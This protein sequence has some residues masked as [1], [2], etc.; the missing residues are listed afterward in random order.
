MFRCQLYPCMQYLG[1]NAFVC[2]CILRLLMAVKFNQT[3]WTQGMPLTMRHI[4]ITAGTQSTAPARI[5]FTNDL[6]LPYI[7]QYLVI[8]TSKFGAPLFS[9]FFSESFS[10]A[11]ALANYCYDASRQGALLCDRLTRLCR[12]R[13]EQ[14]RWIGKV[15]PSVIKKHNQKTYSEIGQPLNCQIDLTSGASLSLINLLG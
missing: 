5:I 1:Q 4:C 13:Q 12:S 7:L 2:F 10:L 14:A 3:T 9:S 6:F 15:G 11:R 8:L